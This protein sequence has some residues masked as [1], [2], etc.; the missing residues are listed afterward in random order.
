[1][2]FGEKK[3]SKLQRISEKAYQKLPKHGC[4]M[5]V[6]LHFLCSHVDFFQE[7]L[8]DFSEEHGK[9]FHQDIK[10]MERRYKG[11]WDS[12]MMGGYIWSLIRQDKSGHKKSS[13]NS[14]FLNDSLLFE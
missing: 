2:D 12:A 8:G 14:A 13:L 7:N 10:P 4:R 3:G 9:R 5:S 1:M 6:K 11:R